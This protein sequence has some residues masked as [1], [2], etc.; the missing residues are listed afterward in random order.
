M[1]TRPS[2]LPHHPGHGLNRREFLRV[3]ALCGVGL[4]LPE[5]LAAKETGLSP[6]ADSC[7]VIFLNGGPSHLDMWDMKPDAPSEIRGPFQSIPTT[8]PGVHLCEYLPRL[9]KQMHRCTLVRSMNHSVNNSHAAAVYAALTGHDR[10]EQGG[11]A[12]PDDHPNL[13]SVLGM[14]RP[15]G[16]A[17]FPYVAL[18]YKTKEGAG[19]PLQ[20]GFLGGIIG[21]NHDPF[22]VLEDPNAP[23]FRVRNLTLPENVS[24]TRMMDRGHLLSGLERPFLQQHVGA[25]TAYEVMNDF[26][27]RAFNMLTSDA[28]QRAFQIEQEPARVREA[29]GRNIYGQSVLLARRLIEAGTRVVTMSWAPDANAT[30]DTHGDNFNK[31][32]NP[33]LPQFDAAAGTLLAE[34]AERGMLG[35][36]LVAVLGD[37]G[38]TPRINNNAGRDHWNACYSVM[39]AGG[40]IKEG[41]VYGASD[42]TGSWPAEHPVSPGDIIST[43]YYLLGVDARSN[44]YDILG[45]PHPLVPAGRVMGELIG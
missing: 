19:G 36:T 29:Y 14:V 43:L 37:F 39:L 17:V 44:I 31:L 13:G 41:L 9:A 35:R 38:R 2:R 12:K 27:R 1:A 22:W 32:K 24:A 4:T 20:P 23:D 28:T 8:L 15:G 6:R 40:G 25:A 18:P 42:P 5:L 30:W 26:Q 21:A 7:I 11:G 34:L 33:L 10:G 16:R 3:G 45:R